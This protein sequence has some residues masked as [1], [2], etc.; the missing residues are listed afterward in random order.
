[1]SLADLRRQHTVTKPPAA[2]SLDDFLEGAQRYAFG[3]S[4]RRTTLQRPDKRP[5][6]RLERPRSVDEG[7]PLHQAHVMLSEQSRTVL[8]EVVDVSGHSRSRVIRI[9]VNQFSHLSPAEQQQ[10]LRR[11]LVR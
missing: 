7:K 10:I 9:L 6:P 11:Y 5:Q 4:E 2:G 1:M 8:S 3:L